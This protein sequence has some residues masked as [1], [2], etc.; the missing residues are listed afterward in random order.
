MEREFGPY[1]LEQ[2]ISEAF[3]CLCKLF[4]DYL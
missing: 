3:A 4:V 1:F 2:E